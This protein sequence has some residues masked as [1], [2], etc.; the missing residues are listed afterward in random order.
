MDATPLTREHFRTL[1]SQLEAHLRWFKMASCKAGI[2]SPYGDT[3]VSI[4]V[5]IEHFGEKQQKALISWLNDAV[6]IDTWFIRL[7][8]VPLDRCEGGIQFTP[9][10]DADFFIADLNAGTARGECLEL[11]SYLPDSAQPTVTDFINACQIRFASNKPFGQ[12]TA[13][14]H[15]CPLP[16]HPLLPV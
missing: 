2:G 13:R 14:Y 11:Q 10:D 15:I 12:T 1:S 9:R 7:Q 3:G 4:T 8:A 16:L 6:R 5:V